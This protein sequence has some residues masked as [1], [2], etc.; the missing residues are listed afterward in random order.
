MRININTCTICSYISIY[1]YCSVYKC[2]EIIISVLKYIPDVQNLISDLQNTYDKE[3]FKQLLSF[4]P[5][6]ILYNEK[7]RTVIT[8]NAFMQKELINE[9][10]SIDKNEEIIKAIN[11]FYHN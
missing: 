2:T 11:I 3:K 10:T 9:I 5:Q 1:I 7:T 8:Y 6:F 4:Y